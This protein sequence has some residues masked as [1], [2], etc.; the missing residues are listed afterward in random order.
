MWKLSDY[1]SRLQKCANLSVSE[2]AASWVFEG[3]PPRHGPGTVRS[4]FAYY[5]PRTTWTIPYQRT[6]LQFNFWSVPYRRTVPV[7]L[8][9][10]RTV[11]FSKNWGVPYRIYVPYRTAILAFNYS[12]LKLS[13]KPLAYTLAISIFTFRVG[14]SCFLPLYESR[15]NVRKV[16]KF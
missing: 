9:T 4:E 10:R 8:Q 14:F 16:W 11:L 3:E 5:V 13:L 15:R 6:L 7:P 1:L 2:G 12:Q